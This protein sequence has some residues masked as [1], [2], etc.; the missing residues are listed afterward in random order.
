M[1]S[2][3]NPRRAARL[4][5]LFILV[6]SAPAALAEI[7]YHLAPAATGTGSGNSRANAALFTN[8]TV[9][10]NANAQLVNG[11][12]TLRFIDGT[13]L[14]KTTNN[15]LSIV[16]L[17]HATNRLTIEGESA[18]GVILKRDPTDQRINDSGYLP[19]L[20][21]VDGC[22]NMTIRHL[23]FRGQEY[24][25][26]AL[27][28]N[29]TKNLLMEECTYIDLHGVYY[30][31]TGTTRNTTTNI[32]FLRCRFERVGMDGHAH[33][34]YNAYD[35]TWLKVEDCHFEDCAG[36]YVRFRDSTDYC[37]VSG[38]TFLSTGSFYNQRTKKTIST[39]TPMITMPL[40]NDDN[41]ATNPPSPNYE[42]FGTNFWF[43]NNQ[44]RYLSAS[45][46][47]RHAVQ[48]HHS[49]FN[50]PGRNHLLTAAEASLLGNTSPDKRAERKALLLANAGIDVDKVRLYNNVYQGVSII[51]S[52]EAEANYGAP[53]TGWNGTV[54]ITDL[55]NQSA[56][57]E[58]G[59]AWTLLE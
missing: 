12:V 30:G 23:N 18:E 46:G 52:Y 59:G 53:S 7:V 20:V 27:Q 15:G 54:N 25:G 43:H 31:A 38:S 56:W 39:H 50:P 37:T 3:F 14:I 9:W 6:A 1:T 21:K 49:G 58:A 33:M 8:I 13:Y 48:F 47:E 22:Q 24:L 36:D 28:I 57:T 5:A 26:Y 17:G 10:N 45:G 29:A 55:I 35:P 4:L 40:F 32:R 16:S 41:P 51:C 42:Y 2:L 34:I 44:F 19:N 11:P